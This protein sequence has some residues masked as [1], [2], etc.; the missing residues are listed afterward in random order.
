MSYLSILATIV[1]I[2]MALAGV[3]QA[4]KIFRRKSVE[5]ISPITYFIISIG[6]IVWVFYGFEIHS[7]AV[8][9]SNALVMLT[10]I[11]VIIE[12]YLFRKSTT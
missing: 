8:I 11:F 4:I 2:V 7:I 12:Y 9:I 6:G 1:G 10:S 3:P 5:D